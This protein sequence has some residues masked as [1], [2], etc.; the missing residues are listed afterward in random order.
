MKYRTHV[1]RHLEE[2]YKYLALK[3]EGIHQ[4]QHPTVPMSSRLWCALM[5][6]RQILGDCL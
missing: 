1:D 2:I 6:E 4:W 5:Y 3:D